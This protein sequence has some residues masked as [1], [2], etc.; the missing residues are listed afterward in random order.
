MQRFVPSFSRKT[1][2]AVNGL[3]PSR[4]QRRWLWAVAI[5]TVMLM[6]LVG[7][8][9]GVIGQGTPSGQAAQPP[10]LEEA[11][12]LNEQAVKL[13]REGKYTE[14]LPLAERALVIREKALGS[15]H[16]DVAQS[17]NTIAELYREKGDYVQAEP[18]YKR[19]LAIR[20]KALGAEHPDFA[21][22]V[23]NL[24]V[25]Y[26]AKG[27][28]VQAEP[29]YKRAL[30]ICEKVFG[31][32]HNNVATTLSGLALVYRIRGDYV[33]A[34]PLYQRAIA[35]REKLFG[36]E[37]PSIATPLS[38][39]ATLYREK[40][41]YIK[42]EQLEQRAL[43]IREK[44]LGSEHPHVA[45]SLNHLAVIY[46]NQGD[47]IKAEQLGQRAL[48]IREKVFGPEHPSVAVSLNNLARLYVAKGDYV[49][50]E[51]LYKRDL[52]IGEKL[53][54]AQHPEVAITLRNLA[55]LYELR[56]DITQAVQFLNRANDIGEHNLALIL[57]TG[58]EDQKR[59]YLNTLSGETNM[60][61]SLHIRS[62]PNDPQAARLALTTI[63]RRKGRILDA[64]SDQFGALHRRLA[65]EDRS[66]LEQL[67]AA[68]SQLATLVLKG[69]GQTNQAQ[70]QAELDKLGTEVERLEE[71]VSARSAEFRA[72]SQPV[73]LDVVQQT[74]PEAT[75]LV[76]LVSY[77]PI[78]LKVE[79]NSVE[80]FGAARYMAYILRKEGAPSVV[81]LG[82]AASIDADIGRLRA[83][84]IN[85]KSLDVKQVAR[86]LDERV[87]RPVRPL[88]GDARK[89]F[90]SPDGALNLIPFEALVDEQ[91]RYLVERY[92][93]TY[94]TSG[95][96]LLRLQV[97][98]TSRSKPLVVANPSFGEPATEQI[99]SAAR[100][101]APKSRR[102]SVTA[103][104][105]LSDTYFAPLSGTA[106]EARTIQ[107]LFPEADLLTGA[108]ATESALKEVAA[109]RVL[110]VATHGFFLQDAETAAASNAQVAVRG[111][112]T[113][114]KIENP[115]LR[116]GL[117]LAGANL[118]GGAGDDGILTALEASGLNLWG[119]KLVVLSA[120]DTGVGEVRN[121]E[122]VYGLRRSFVLA[123]AESLVMSLWPISD[124]ATRTLMTD[125]YKNLKQ[126]MGRGAALRQVQLEMLKRNR[127]LHPFYWANFIQ[128]GEWAS[129]DGKR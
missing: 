52:A 92:S 64:L 33:R 60:T 5:F 61:L 118:R 113:D 46:K 32:E 106:Q 26:Y 124:Y 104:R 53:L 40:G 128:S 73:T 109:P 77:R 70:H 43:V 20:E 67:S 125:Y 11:K 120:C 96:D 90:L 79:K 6:S 59:L 10:E 56:G 129:L 80:R 116:S 107:T 93:F 24:A 48:A 78:N 51:P 111:I 8:P 23:N 1:S 18:L 44:A 15:Q 105:S 83:A 82:E 89:V 12:R 99:A 81:E 101:V 123:G 87:M 2:S 3:M 74:L 112:K 103:A 98:R 54:G 91:G 16:L 50:A 34:E 63:L 75:A 22:S 88:L 100:P 55:E 72:Q 21:E 126:G 94:L 14:A 47:Y 41:D 9:R 13:H 49:Q 37:H 36:A 122:G 29:L 127:Q 85:V 95:R 58:S 76:E 114:V 19:A 119:T 4:S 42:A 57:T 7:A 62:A 39:F 17:L 35:I 110:H 31:A 30:A 71:A 38:N 27:D 121:G 102:R 108:R 84:L 66:L 69:P 65:P 97:A 68:R 117:A 115:L 45:A 28:Y 86:A 25:L